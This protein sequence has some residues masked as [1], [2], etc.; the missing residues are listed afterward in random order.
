MTLIVPVVTQS[1]VP[2]KSGVALMAR[3]L[4]N[5]G[6]PILQATISSIGYTV[7]NLDDSTITDVTGSFTVSS[8]IY[9]SLQ[10]SDLTWT[11]DDVDNPGTDGR[12]GYNFKDV[13]PASAFTPGNQRYQVDVKFTPASGQVFYVVFQFNTTRIYAT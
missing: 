4:G 11:K 10:R 13:V 8:A 9:D 7:H 1:A 6:E 12:Y 3:V 5:N 2:A